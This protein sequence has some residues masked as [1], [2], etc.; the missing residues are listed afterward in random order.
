MRIIVVVGV[1]GA[2]GA[3]GGH[4]VVVTAGTTM[5]TG[6]TATMRTVRSPR[7]VVRRAV[8]RS[9]V[10]LGGTASRA[11][12]VRVVVNAAAEKKNTEKAQGGP[13][14]TCRR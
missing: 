5:R 6:S 10:P 7:R 4:G 11:V 8:V 3:A 13:F 2:G 9:T 1:A 14:P 12:A